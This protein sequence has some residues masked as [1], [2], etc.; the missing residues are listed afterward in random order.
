[1]RKSWATR[2]VALLLVV[3]LVT[4]FLAVSAAPD[5]GAVTGIWPVGVATASLPAT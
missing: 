1:V 2:V 4:G 3:T 5:D